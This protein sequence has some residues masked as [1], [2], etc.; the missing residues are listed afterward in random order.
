MKNR[1]SGA[2]GR[3]AELCGARAGG[4]TRQAGQQAGP[5]QARQ[6]GKGEEEGRAGSRVGPVGEFFPNP[7]FFPILFS[8]FKF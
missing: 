8:P 2:V 1:A 6:A 3:C 5:R 7:I 4:K